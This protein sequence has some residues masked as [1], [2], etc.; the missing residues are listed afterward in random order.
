MTR[1]PLY[2]YQLSWNLINAYQLNFSYLN[3]WIQT[4]NVLLVTHACCKV[5][6]PCISSESRAVN[7]A[8]SNCV[9]SMSPKWLQDFNQPCA[10]SVRHSKTALL[11]EVEG[12]TEVA[13][14][15]LSIL[16]NRGFQVWKW[17]NPGFCLPAWWRCLQVSG[18][19][20]RYPG[21]G[22]RW[23]HPKVGK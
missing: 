17:W 6:L 23:G 2:D 5:L 11:R 12:E 8:A 13:D 20:G 21:C 16:M 18:L 3:V 14:L 15:H 4:F 7:G 22:W 9:A 1:N 19:C 10:C